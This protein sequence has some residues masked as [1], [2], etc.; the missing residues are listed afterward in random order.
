MVKNNENDDNE[1]Y[2]HSSNNDEDDDNIYENEIKDTTENIDKDVYD[3][4]AYKSFGH[5]ISLIN[6]PCK[7]YKYASYI[8]DDNYTDEIKCNLH[9]NNIVMIQVQ[10]FDKSYA[11]IK[12]I[13]KHKGNDE[14][15]YP[16][17]YVDWFEDVHQN[18]DKLG[19][20]YIFFVTII[21]SARFCLYLL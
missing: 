18:C 1:N 21:L 8:Q 4:L 3:P 19:Y 11:I 15:Y 13:F 6:E 7:F 5:Y 9:K 2:D 12:A 20:H 10:D 17:I 16:F 14:Q